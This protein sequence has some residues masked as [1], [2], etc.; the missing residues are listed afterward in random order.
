[1]VA[2]LNV[3]THASRVTLEDLKARILPALR[4]TAESVSR[5]MGAVPG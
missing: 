2:A 5:A 4:E 3:G 1:M